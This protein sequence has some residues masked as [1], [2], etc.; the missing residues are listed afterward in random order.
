LATLSCPA[1][2]VLAATWGSSARGG[3][4]E[5]SRRSAS[6]SPPSLLAICCSTPGVASLSVV[7]EASHQVIPGQASPIRL[8]PEERCFVGSL[9]GGSF[10]NLVFFLGPGSCSGGTGYLPGPRG[11][12]ARC[13]SN[14]DLS[15]NATPPCRSVLCYDTCSQPVWL[16]SC[17]LELRTSH[18]C[19]CPLVL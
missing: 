12:P 10:R 1:S 9:S 17:T 7:V 3:G 15:G 16:P 8:L 18:K 11:S 4:T 2:R 13:S 19:S 14:S 5:A 6:A